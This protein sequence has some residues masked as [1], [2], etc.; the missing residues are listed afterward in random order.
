MAAPP[1]L[2]APQPCP[3][4]WLPIRLLRDLVLLELLVEIAPRRV[5]DLGR[6]GNVPAV[7]AELGDEEG[8]FGIV[9][10]FAQGACLRRV[11]VGSRPGRRRAARRRR[12][13]WR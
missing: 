8:T 13:E 12:R 1:D 7:F 2:P 10:E 9:L 11:P 5:D 6:P 4:D 3:P